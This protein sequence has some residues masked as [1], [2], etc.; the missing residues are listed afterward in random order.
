MHVIV[1][2]A[3]LSHSCLLF[4]TAVMTQSKNKLH[5]C[6]K[7]PRA[8]GQDQGLVVAP[9]IA[10][11]EVS[12]IALTCV[13]GCA[14]SSPAAGT[15]QKSQRK[16]A[17][18]FPDATISCVSS[19]KGAKSQRE[20]NPS[21]Y[22]ASPSSLSSCKDLLTRK[23]GLSMQVFMDKYKMKDHVTKEE[24][25]KIFDKKYRAHFPEIFKRAAEHIEL[26]F[27]LDLKDVDPRH[28]SYILVGKLYLPNEGSLSN[29]GMA[30]PKKGILM[31]LLGMTFFNSNCAREEEMWKF[32]NMM[33]LYAGRRHFI[34]GEPREL[35]TT[36]SVQQKLLGCQQVPNS[37]PIRY[38]F[39]G[40]PRAHAGS[41]KMQALEY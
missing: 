8:L 17:S 32:L 40:G 6:E 34:F 10:A 4:R 29:D 39:L 3:F 18:S 30:F 20:E 2:L 22:W 9:A 26:A 36:D 24:M 7:R 5:A 11:G 33:G 21:S 28:H 37:D 31:P 35:I 16:R 14:P 13:R 27:G 19:G 23:I 1:S 15:P 38:K 12:L 41:R 25:L